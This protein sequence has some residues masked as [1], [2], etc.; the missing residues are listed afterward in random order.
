VSGL[1]L[2]LLSTDGMTNYQSIS[3]CACISENLAER[4]PA[5]WLSGRVDMPLLST[6]EVDHHLGGDS[7]W[8]QRRAFEWGLLGR[9][10]QRNGDSNTARYCFERIGLLKKAHP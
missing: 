4:L 9:V 5:D 8:E 1:A 2:Q 3:T 6:A 10:F 7:S